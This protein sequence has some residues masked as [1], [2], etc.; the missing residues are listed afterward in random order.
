[1]GTKVDFVGFEDTTELNENPVKSAEHWKMRTKLPGK[2]G[3]GYEY[4][5]HRTNNSDVISHRIDFNVSGADIPGGSILYGDFQVQHDLDSFR[6]VFT[7][8]AECMKNNVLKCPSQQ[9]Q[10]WEKN[11]FKHDYAL[12]KAHTTIV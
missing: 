2:I 12:S 3:I 8:P 11:H 10:S 9:V 1:M 7:P 4:F 5:V 6:D